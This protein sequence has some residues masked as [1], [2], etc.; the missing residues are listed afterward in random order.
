MSKTPKQEE[1]SKAYIGRRG[2]ESF[3]ASRSGRLCRGKGGESGDGSPGRWKHFSFHPGIG[4]EPLES[5]PLIL[6]L[7]QTGKGQGE[8]GSRRVA[9]SIAKI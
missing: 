3:Q 1:M 2:G 8:I 4:A 9:E 6:C 7:E 5:F